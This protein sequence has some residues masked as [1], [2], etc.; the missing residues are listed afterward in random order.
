MA[1]KEEWWERMLKGGAA[2]GVTGAA[3]GGAPGAGVGML[4]GGLMGL[5]GGG[6]DEE[7]YGFATPPDPKFFRAPEFE[8]TAGARKGWWEKLQEWG[9]QPGYGAIAP[10]W[11]DIWQRAKK[12]VSQYYWGGPEGGPG[13]AGKVK[14]SAARRGVAE[15]PAGE[16]MLMRMGATEAGQLGDIGTEMSLQEALFGEKGRQSWLQ[17]IAKMSGL[18]VPGVWQTARGYTPAGAGETPWGD[19]ATAGGQYLGQTGQQKQQQDW[20]EKILNQFGPGGGEGMTPESIIY[21]GGRGMPT[22]EEF[23]KT[24]AWAK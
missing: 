2:G 15:S 7:E 5:F 3:I 20:L 18:Q 22:S 13:L 9:Q 1:K 17:N 19:L 10:D 11:G 21:G 24:P 16:T 14:A 8:E 12:R 4:G 6:D 23:Y